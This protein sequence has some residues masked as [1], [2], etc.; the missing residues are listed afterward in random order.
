[1]EPE[2]QR[3]LIQPSTRALWQKGRR[4]PGYSPL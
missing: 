1:M 3:R 2:T 4:T